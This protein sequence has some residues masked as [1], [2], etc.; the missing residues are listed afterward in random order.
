MKVNKLSF[1]VLAVL[2][3]IAVS[4]CSQQDYDIQIP[5]RV[6]GDM[7]L[8]NKNLTKDL[9]SSSN[10]SFEYQISDANEYI[11]YNVYVEN[12][13]LHSKLSYKQ[14]D[15]KWVDI[16]EMNLHY[17]SS[18]I[19]QH[20]IHQYELMKTNLKIVNAVLTIVI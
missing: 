13:Q 18:I 6:Y 11:K 15:A 7:N 2:C 3:C 14:N 10:L 5:E 8:L 1:F 16:S 19:W 20:L 12:N 4:S 17:L 9:N